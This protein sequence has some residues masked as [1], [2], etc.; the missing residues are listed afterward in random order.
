MGSLCVRPCL[1]APR[2]FLGCEGSPWPRAWV[3]F[4]KSKPSYPNPSDFPPLPPPLSP[5]RAPLQDNALLVN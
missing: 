5:C 3:S 2:L 4:A 1:I